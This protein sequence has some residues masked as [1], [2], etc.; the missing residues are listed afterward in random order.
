VVKI[1]EKRISLSE[2]E[3]RL[4]MLDGILDAAVLTVTRGSRQRGRLAGPG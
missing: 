2:V 4:L 1:E 3:Q